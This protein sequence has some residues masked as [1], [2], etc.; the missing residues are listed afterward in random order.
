MVVIRAPRHRPAMPSTIGHSDRGAAVALRPNWP[1][2]YAPT[3][4]STPATGLSGAQGRAW[5]GLDGRG[6]VQRVVDQAILCPLSLW[7]QQPRCWTGSRPSPTRRTAGASQR[8][9]R[10]HR[11]ARGQRATQR[12]P[13]LVRS[14]FTTL[15]ACALAE[16][17]RRKAVFAH[18]TRE[19]YEDSRPKRFAARRDER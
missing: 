1:R 16:R 12:M 7:R 14:S 11:P 8:C 15:A 9:G 3:K 6:L 17:C 2:I 5:H 19:D 4:R 10:R 13:F 18:I